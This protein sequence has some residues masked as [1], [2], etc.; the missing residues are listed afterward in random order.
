MGFGGIYYVQSSNLH[1]LVFILG[2]FFSLPAVM[3]ILNRVVTFFSES[4]V[5]VVSGIWTALR[6]SYQSKYQGDRENPRDTKTIG[7]ITI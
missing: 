3:S 6:V 7:S 4:F 1:R 2:S 5:V